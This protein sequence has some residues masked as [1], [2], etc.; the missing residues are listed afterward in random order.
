[1]SA[2][3]SGLV[4]SAH[5]ASLTWSRAA[6]SLVLVVVLAARSGKKPREGR[7]VL[8]GLRAAPEGSWALKGGMAS[9]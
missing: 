8:R 2:V 6:R 5:L 7:V 9:R 3:Y 1:M 4:R